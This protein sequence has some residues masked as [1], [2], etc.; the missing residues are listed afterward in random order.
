M[1]KI[2]ICNCSK[3]NHHFVQQALQKKFLEDG[4]IHILNRETKIIEYDKNLEDI[5]E[6]FQ[7]KHLYPKIKLKELEKI[8]I[9]KEL[10][11]INQI[12][13]K[14]DKCIECNFGECL[15]NKFSN[16]INKIENK[17]NEK[18]NSSKIHK[19]LNNEDLK[20]IKQ[21]FYFQYG[22]TPTAIED[23][24]S[25][26]KDWEIPGK[27]HREIIKFKKGK[28]SWL[29]LL[30]SNEGE[31]ILLNLFEKLNLKIII[32]QTDVSFIL[33][34]EGLFWT[35]KVNNKKSFKD[36]QIFLP[37]HPKILLLFEEGDSETKINQDKE[38]I[39]EINKY[40]LKNSESNCFI[41]GDK[42]YLEKLKEEI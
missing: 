31:S 11:G 27:L 3:K 17:Y 7:K 4:K 26:I 9:L 29:I 33:G 1:H 22:R 36:S 28:Y 12:F 15:E 35:G 30:V 20:I 14:K 24:K 10:E 40:N 8:S 23:F 19:N 6:N 16:V 41:S 13:T 32:N 42:K 21:Y 5:R 18:N 34:G 2:E 25:K 39:H 38:D 37:I